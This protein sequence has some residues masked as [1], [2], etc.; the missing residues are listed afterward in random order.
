MYSGYDANGNMTSAPG[1]TLT[2]N[3]DNM[4]SSINSTT[5]VYDYSGHRVKKNSTIYIGKLYEC[6]GGSCSK[7]IFAGNNR[8]ALRTSSN[9]YYYH[10]DH[11]G[12][13]SVM[14]KQD[15]TNYGEF[16]YHPYGTR[17][18]TSGGSGIR[19]KFTG[20]EEDTET[21]LY[22]YG[23]R[24]YDPTIGRFISADSIVPAPGNP[25]S[26]NRYSYVLNNPLRYTDPTGHGFWEKVFGVFEVILGAVLSY[27]P[28]YPVSP[29]LMAHGVYNIDNE[30]NIDVRAQTPVASW[31]GSANGGGLTYIGSGSGYYSN[32]P[33]VINTNQ[34]PSSTGSSSFASDGYSGWNNV[35]TIN[36]E[37]FAGGGR[38]YSYSNYLE[39]EGVSGEPNIG[40]PYGGNSSSN[41]GPIDKVDAT[42]SIAGSYT[43]LGS[44][45]YPPLRGA[46]MLIT[47]GQIF[48]YGYKYKTGDIT[49]NEF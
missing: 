22:N 28:A 35:A 18:F 23:A 27:T 34:A 26:L 36:P 6:T 25:Q 24:Y 39:F 48:Y 16:Y 5:F 12:S 8:I 40:N 17:W 3:Y 1:K 10:T 32:A 42:L 19:H 21:G 20:Q 31:G 13:S 7:Y 43:S 41:I 29:L 11:L 15:G 38:G 2:Y 9:T 44:I 33:G 4:P 46:G 49:A 37:I 30:A 45:A 14:T 47:G